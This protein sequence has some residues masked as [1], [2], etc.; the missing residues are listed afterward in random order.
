MDLDTF[1]NNMK[2]S[3]YDR[4]NKLS[5]SEVVNGMELTGTGLEDT[6]KGSDSEQYFIPWRF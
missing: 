1:F 3:R 5:A 4:E 6:L 2:L